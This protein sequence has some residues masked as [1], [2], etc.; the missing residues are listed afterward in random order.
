MIMKQVKRDSLHT[1]FCTFSARREKDSVTFGIEHAM[2]LEPQKG[3]IVVGCCHPG[4]SV[5]VEAAE[6]VG[7]VY[8][9]IGGLHWFK[10][11]S[12]FEGYL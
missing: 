3:A 1:G 9:V 6:R 8:M 11:L 4:L 12:Q 7:K 2:V 10:D 5:F